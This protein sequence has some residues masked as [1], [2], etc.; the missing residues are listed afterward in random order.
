MCSFLFLFEDQKKQHVYFMNYMDQN[1]L[2]FAIS[3][4]LNNNDFH[5]GS[6]HNILDSSNYNFYQKA[7]SRTYT[8]TL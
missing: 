6:F 2:G 5:L 8:L 1:W 3:E 4:I 7:L